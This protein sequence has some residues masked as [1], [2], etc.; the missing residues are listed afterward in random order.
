[1]TQPID[2]QRRLVAIFA[3]DVEGYSRMMGTD[4]VGTLRALSERRV[5]LDTLISSHRGRIANTAGDSVL[6]EFGSAVDAVHC[7][8]AAQAALAEANAGAAPDRPI[9]F[10]IGV[11]V[12]DVM[13]KDGDLFGDSVNVAA[14]LQTLASPGGVSISGAVYDHVR[15]ILPFSFADLGAQQVKN[16]EDPVQAY[17]VTALKSS[18][19]PDVARASPHKQPLALPDKPSIA[20][21]PFQNLS[22]DLEQEYFADGMVEEITTAI[23]RLPWLFVIARNS[24][25]TY[26]GKAVDVKQVARELGVR[27]VMEGSV[28]R[29]GNRMRITGQLI[30]TAS[31]THIWANHFD[32]ALED[33]FE[34]QDQVASG[35]VGAI[36]PRLYRAEIERA[37]RKPTAILDAY[38]L[39]LRA[40]SQVH[41]MTPETLTEAI[42]LSKRAL[43][44]DPSYAAAAGLAAWCRGIQ[45]GQGWVLPAGPEDDDGIRLA[46]LA[47][48]V[49]TN[50]PD[51]LWM[52][53]YLLSVVGEQTT[54]LSA[55]DRAIALNPNSAHAW[56][57]KAMC[58]SLRGAAH[59]LVAVEAGNRAIRLNPLDP[60]C[61]IY[62]FAV[63][64]AYLGARQYQDAEVWIDDALR[65]QPRFHASFRVK[66][67]LCGLLG[68]NDEALVWLGRLL[69]LQPGL[70]IA[71]WTA[72]AATFLA[73]ETKALMIEGLRQAGL[74]DK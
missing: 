7:A 57:T 3:A 41:R 34:L 23:A 27:Y 72:H 64:L 33:I 39:Y 51:A 71:A 50:D 30:D 35:V 43:Q 9:N 16:I 52:A 26:K 56:G 10:R 5:I 25:F 45:R 6:A 59:A 19:T 67:S 58:Q 42:S 46:K 66:V 49:G 37:S 53:A 48:E 17:S 20:V 61:Y 32:G 31:G 73:P 28:R 4:E 8:V 14:R 24:S 65:E 69:A 29:G 63:A 44:L 55:L 70:T 15:K 38:D 62:K 47:I 12:G 2:T 54:A 22:G 40:L 60:L 18:A 1:M 74:P 21:L 11:H 13:V 36:E 68:R